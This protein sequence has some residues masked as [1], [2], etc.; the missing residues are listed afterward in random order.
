MPTCSRVYTHYTPP[1]ASHTATPPHGLRQ[2]Y[3]FLLVLPQ[4]IC[5]N[6]SRSSGCPQGILCHSGHRERG[7]GPGKR[8][9]GGGGGAGRAPGRVT[10]TVC[11]C[12]S[13]RVMAQHTPAC[14]MLGAGCWG[15]GGRGERGEEQPGGSH[16]VGEADPWAFLF[17]AGGLG[18]CVHMC[19]PWTPL[20][21]PGPH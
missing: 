4:G 18:G 11:I 7:Q 10:L 16:R 14:A 5:R 1:Q 15:M 2:L 20:Q 13:E 19:V 3:P 6:C 12:V 17:M 9:G 8:H 21:T